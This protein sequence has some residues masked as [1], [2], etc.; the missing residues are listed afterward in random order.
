MIFVH[1]HPLEGNFCLDTLNLSGVDKLR[2]RFIKT[3][4]WEIFAPPPLFGWKNDRKICPTMEMGS[5]GSCGPSKIQW[6]RLYKHYTYIRIISIHFVYT[7]YTFIPQSNP[8]LKPWP[9]HFVKKK[10]SFSGFSLCIP[11]FAKK[12]LLTSPL[13]WQ[14]KWH[15]ITPWNSSGKK[16]KKVTGIEKKRRENCRDRFI[17]R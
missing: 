2:V 17:D 8:F 1:S 15:R 16:F 12:I 3:F 10:K 6:L 7:K 13:S 5:L 11:S 9:Y 14:P 4:L